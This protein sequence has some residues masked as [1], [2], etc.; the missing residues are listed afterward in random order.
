[1]RSFNIFFDLCAW[2][3]VW[4]NNRDD[5]DLRRHRAHCYV[6]AMSAIEPPSP[7]QWIRVKNFYAQ[8]LILYFPQHSYLSYPLYNIWGCVFSVYPFPMWWVREYIYIYIYF[9]LL[10]S[11]NRRYEPHYP[12]F[13]VR[14]WNS[15]MRRMS[16]YILIVLF[17]IILITRNEFAKHPDIFHGIFR[18]R[19]SRL[20]S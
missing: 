9:V 6:I 12:L 18:S 11:S 5:G 3:N 16:L 19:H 2:T 10:S 20:N 13:R 17:M 15:Y 7:M 1:M 4:V 14:S 8:K